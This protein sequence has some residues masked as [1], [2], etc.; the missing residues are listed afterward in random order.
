MKVHVNGKT[1]M[2]R[3]TNFTRGVIAVDKADVEKL[4]K[5][6]HQERKKKKRKRAK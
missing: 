1:P 2:E 6:W 4:D 3:L 5:Q